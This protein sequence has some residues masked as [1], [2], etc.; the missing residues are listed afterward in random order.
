M[1]TKRT[2]LLLARLRLALQMNSQ[3]AVLILL[4]LLRLEGWSKKQVEFLL[5]QPERKMTVS[6]PKDMVKRERAS[7][8]QTVIFAAEVTIPAIIVSSVF[9]IVT[10][11]Q[12]YPVTFQ[13][14]RW[15]GGIVINSLATL[16]AS[17]YRVFLES[18]LVNPKYAE[19]LK[20]P[21]I[22]LALEVW[23][24]LGLA[25]KLAVLRR[26][27]K[28]QALIARRPSKRQPR[29]ELG[30]AKTL[31]AFLLLAFANEGWAELKS[32]I[33]KE[34]KLNPIPLFVLVSVVCGL[35]TALDSI[36]AAPAVVVAT[37]VQMQSINPA[38]TIALMYLPTLTRGVNTGLVSIATGTVRVM[39]TSILLGLCVG[40][41]LAFQSSGLYKRV[42]L[43][44][45]LLQSLRLFI[46]LVLQQS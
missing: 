45:P 1:D 41:D 5:R 11:D 22:F 35:L 8:S 21:R 4:F 2:N 27:K 43:L 18:I 6:S 26:P 16:A 39:V 29:E 9:Y 15:F 44:D 46:K 38:I 7:R 33:A 34:R 19:T 31:Q 28:L 12:G 40:A 14:E 36:T 24:N 23:Q 37:F 42:G 30:S 13:I 3:E 17:D 20:D 10:K 25:G 32:G